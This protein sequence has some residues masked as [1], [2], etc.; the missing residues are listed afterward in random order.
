MVM[1][2]Q[3]TVTD[4]MGVCANVLKD[5]VVLLVPSPRCSRCRLFAAYDFNAVVFQACEASV[6]CSGHGSTTPAIFQQTQIL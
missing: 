2:K 6:D 3:W 1:V 5:L 4:G